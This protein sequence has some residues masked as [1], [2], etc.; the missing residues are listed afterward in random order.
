MW[1]AGG[2]GGVLG[3][4]V[5]AWGEE[6]CVCVEIPAV[7]NTFG[8]CGMRETRERML[9]CCRRSQRGPLNESKADRYRKVQK[10]P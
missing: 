6:L 5:G 2:G 3:L 10:I 1:G 7:E 8:F 9:S 4:F